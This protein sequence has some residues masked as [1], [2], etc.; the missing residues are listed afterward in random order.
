VG[1]AV[2]LRAFDAEVRVCPPDENSAER[3]AVSREGRQRRVTLAG[4]PGQDPERETCK[5]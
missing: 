2:R 1:L 3:L 4:S 5:P